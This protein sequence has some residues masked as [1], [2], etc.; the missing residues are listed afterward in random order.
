VRTLYDLPI[1]HWRAARSL[2]LEEAALEPEWAATL[3]GNRD[4]PAKTERKDAE[5]AQADV[6]FV[7]SAYTR[8]T[9]TEAADFKGAVMVVPYGAPDA[10]PARPAGAARDETSKKLRVLFVG[11]LGQRKGLSYLFAACRR[12]GSAVTLTVIGRKT[13]APC[14]ALDRELAGVRWIPTATH[15]VVLREM[16]AHDVFV[17]PSLFEGFGLVLL[18]ALAMGLP[19]VTPAHTAGPDL[20]EE[21]V[22]GFIVPIRDA[23]AIAARLELLHRDRA[24]L[25]EMSR[26]ARLRAL[27]HTWDNYEQTLAACVERALS[28]A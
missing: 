8:R 9:L 2:L 26:Q 16:A 17:F 13:D 15:R 25:A 20:I 19:I 23:A 22:Q 7:A 4:S 6:V 14:A 21:G 12:V 18:E 28:G 11:S 10:P 3:I 1:G 24:R 5:L 27:E